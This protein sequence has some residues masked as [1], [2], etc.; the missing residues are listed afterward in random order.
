M[1]DGTDRRK[2]I[3]TMDQVGEPRGSYYAASMVGKQTLL[4]VAASDNM[5]VDKNT[6]P[7]AVERWAERPI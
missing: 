4:L 7:P 3:Q 2:K 5:E 1:A 6:S